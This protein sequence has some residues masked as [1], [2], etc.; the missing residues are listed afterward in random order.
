MDESSYIGGAT[1]TTQIV[2]GGAKPSVYNQL[3]RREGYNA[4]ESYYLKNRDG[5]SSHLPASARKEA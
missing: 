3:R 5:S 2:K 1:D 4:E